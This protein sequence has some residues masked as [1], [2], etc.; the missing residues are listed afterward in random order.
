VSVC[1]C[2]SKTYKKQCLTSLVL[3]LMDFYNDWFRSVFGHLPSF[4]INLGE[5]MGR[6]AVLYQVVRKLIVVC[7]CFETTAKKFST[8]IV[9]EKKAV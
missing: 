8:P 9:D 5:K 7:F 6:I 3:S 2:P 1:I 4:A